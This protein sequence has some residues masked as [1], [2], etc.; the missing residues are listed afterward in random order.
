[1]NGLVIYHGPT[2]WD[3]FCSAWLMHHFSDMD[4]DYHP[5]QYGEL[6]PNVRNRDVWVLDFSY[7]RQSMQV[8]AQEAR[9]LIVL[10]HHKT[11]QAALE[12]LPYCTF[13]MGLSGAQL[14]WDWLADT[15]GHALP[16]RPWLVDYTADRDL[17]KWLLPDSKEVNA[18][19]RSYPLDFAVWDRL[20]AEES[21]ATLKR[22]G[23]AILRAEEVTIQAH[24]ARAREIDFDGYQILSVNATSLYSEIAG[25]LAEGRDF[26]MCWFERDGLRQYSLR[27]REGGIDVS[28]IAKAHGGGGHRGA[29][30]FEVPLRR[31]ED[32][33]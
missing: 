6:P 25:R 14:T 7:P 20:W 13:D 18:A 11:A 1:M 27:S 21:P 3:G 17:W 31:E 32:I 4:L 23:A 28:E 22:D 15:F 24:L 8:M 30:G 19:L 26:G 33:R 12:G 16:K 9:S 29:A 10:D 5:A 2:C